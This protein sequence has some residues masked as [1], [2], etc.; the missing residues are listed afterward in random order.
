MERNRF[1]KDK[2]IMNNK[3]TWF[4]GLMQI[5]FITFKLLNVIE[6]SWLWV[7]APMWLPIVTVISSIIV[8][9][10]MTFIKDMKRG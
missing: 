9:L 8:L 1:R 7:L 6:C 5:L 10:V 2:L 3:T 4:L